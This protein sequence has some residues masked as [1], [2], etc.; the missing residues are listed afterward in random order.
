MNH[1]LAKRH[2]EQFSK[3]SK[4]RIRNVSQRPMAVI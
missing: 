3:V 2:S 1:N 4:H